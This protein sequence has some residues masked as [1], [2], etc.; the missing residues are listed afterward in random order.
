MNTQTEH[1]HI[2]HLVTDVANPTY[3]IV[4]VAHVELLVRDLDASARFYVEV[5]GLIESDRTEEAVYLRGWEERVHHSLVLRKADA[6]AVGHVSFR[7]REPGDLELLERECQDKGL[8]TSWFTDEPHHLAT[9]DIER[10]II[11]GAQLGT[12]GKASAAERLGETA[13]RKQRFLSHHS[14]R[15]LM[16]RLTCPGPTGSSAGMVSRHASTA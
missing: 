13:H 2:E 3:D 1:V 9:P 15:H 10:N 8:R 7:V 5:L 12:A 16:H 11:D 14:S 4:R 6:A